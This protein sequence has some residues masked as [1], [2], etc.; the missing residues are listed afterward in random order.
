MYHI[1]LIHSFVNGHVG[2][3]HVLAIVTSAAINIGEHV[4]I[5]F[6][7]EFITFIAVQLSSQG[8]IYMCVY[9]CIYIYIYIFFFRTCIFLKERFV[10]IYA[11]EWD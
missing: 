9:V 11:Q 1:F 10:R 5:Y 4:Y 2:C 8:Y 6:L 7:N 3:S